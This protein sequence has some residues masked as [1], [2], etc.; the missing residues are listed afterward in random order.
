M[1]LLLRHQQDVDYLMHP[2]DINC[3]L[4]LD[5][6]PRLLVDQIAVEDEYTKYAI[7]TDSL[8]AF[9]ALIKNKT[10]NYIVSRIHNL[11]N[12]SDMPSCHVVWTPSHRGISINEEVDEVANTAAEVGA[13]LSVMYTPSEA[14]LF[15]DQKLKH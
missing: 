12:N 5:T 13:P 7:F 15:T 1:L 3:Y 6:C 4:K 2:M 11:L 8:A 9:K 10:D 14:I